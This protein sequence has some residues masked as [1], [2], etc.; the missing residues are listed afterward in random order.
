MRKVGIIRCQQTEDACPCPHYAKM[1]DAV[2]KAV[3]DEI[4]IVEYTH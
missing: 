2:A 4:G 1:R 3:G